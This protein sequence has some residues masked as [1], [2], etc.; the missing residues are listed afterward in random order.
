M[1]VQ[2][3]MDAVMQLDAHDALPSKLT[4]EDWKRLAPY[5][6]MRFLHPDEVLMQAGETDR[7]LY[8][9]SE[10][11]LQVVVSNTVLAT[12]KPGTV[13]GEGT[14]FSGEARSATVMASMP[15]VAWS[16]SPERFK[17]LSAKHPKVALD[18]VMALA[19]LLAIRMRQAILVG[20]FA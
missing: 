12:L 2:Q 8:I 15:G 17:A 14:F 13:V 10:G 7:D 6:S 20:H 18:L 9:L 19:T 16:L 3:L 11:E 4:L 1:N 5:L